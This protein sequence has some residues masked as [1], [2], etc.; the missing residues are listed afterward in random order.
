MATAP[1]Q[2]TE[3]EQGRYIQANGLDIYYEEH[4]QGKPLLLIHGGILTGGSWQP[5]LAVF[6]KHY[7]VIT[8]DSRGHGRTANPAGSLSFELLADDMAA[9]IQA[10]DLQKPL[11]CGYSDGGQVALEI[12]MRYPDLPQALIIGGAYVELTEASRKWVRSILG[13]EQSPD[14]D[15]EQ[16]ERDNPTFAAGLQ[17]DHGP[18]DWK[19]LLK[20]IKPM[21]NATLNYSQDDFARVVAPTLVLLGDR[22]G[23]VPV[24]EGV[25]MY[26]LLP[27]AEFAVI[28]GAE[29]NDFIFSPAK[30]ELLQPLIMDFL[31]RHSDSAGQT[32]PAEN[33][34]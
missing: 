11:I 32:E 27:N 29:H 23:F 17:Q 20:Q 15:I 12:G 13:D 30:V 5:Y 8:P 21:W 6:A 28:P 18:E 19:T 24:E 16:F 3:S 2:Q 31:S 22:D 33:A 9:L 26:R 10:L 14:V 7:R 34:H 25:S 1:L 4:G